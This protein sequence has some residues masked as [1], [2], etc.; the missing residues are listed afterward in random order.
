MPEPN[1]THF[2][3][4]RMR[5]DYDLWKCATCHRQLIQPSVPHSPPKCCGTGMW[6]IQFLEGEPY[7]VSVQLERG[8]ASW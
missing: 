3:V 8:P 1:R 4:H 2:S 5:T 6:W 7:Q